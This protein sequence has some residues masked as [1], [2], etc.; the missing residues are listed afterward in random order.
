MLMASF[1]ID[2]FQRQQS[3]SLAEGV[4]HKFGTKQENQA[5]Q[6]NEYPRVSTEFYFH[7]QVLA[8]RVKT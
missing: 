7:L 6:L 3:H 8:S 4:H 1:P 5:F 2:R